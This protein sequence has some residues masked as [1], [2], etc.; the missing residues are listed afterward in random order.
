MTQYWQF[1]T[2]KTVIKRCLET[3][4]LGISGQKTICPL[5]PEITWH[6]EM[7]LPPGGGPQPE[8]R[9]DET[10]RPLAKRNRYPQF[11]RWHEIKTVN[12]IVL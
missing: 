5:Y 2:E 11:H 1:V 4:T 8:G 10:F 3:T 6:S 7:T 9:E 12:G